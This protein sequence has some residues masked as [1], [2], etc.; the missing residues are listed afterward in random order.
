MLNLIKIILYKSTQQNPFPCIGHFIIF[1][2]HLVC[3]VFCTVWLLTITG[4]SS[5][6]SVPCKLTIIGGFNLVKKNAIVYNEL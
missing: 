1:T 4:Y 2:G 5:Y 6:G 3:D